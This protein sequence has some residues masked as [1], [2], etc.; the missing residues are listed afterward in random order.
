MA[1]YALRVVLWYQG[2][3][4]SASDPAYAERYGCQFRAMITVWRQRWGVD[5]TFCFVQLS[6]YPREPEGNGTG[7]FWLAPYRWA[8][9]SALPRAGGGVE[10]TAIAV[11][12]DLGDVPDGIQVNFSGPVATGAVAVLEQGGVVIALDCATGADG[13]IELK[14]TL[15]CNSCCAD[16]P[17]EL[18]ADCGLMWWTAPAVSRD[19]GS[20]S[21]A[22]DSSDFEAK[23]DARALRV[24]QPPTVRALQRARAPSATLPARS[25]AQP[26]SGK[27][28]ICLCVD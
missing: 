21:R 13:P 12:Y 24:A 5:V 25:G 23:R 6:A 4:N 1:G 16:S 8:Q 19:D 27:S 18:S 22:R 9:A 14:C 17:F 7:Q 2:E 20:V 15:D 11:A 3:A 10:T 26:H 28:V